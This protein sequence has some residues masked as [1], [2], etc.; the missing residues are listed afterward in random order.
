MES[1]ESI[2][3]LEKESTKINKL[4]SKNCAH[5]GK[6]NARSCPCKLAA[7]CDLECQRK[8]W[9]TH[10]EA[11][12]AKRAS[13]VALE[14]AAVKAAA[15]LKSLALEEALDA[16]IEAEKEVTTEPLKEMEKFFVRPNNP[17]DLST[18]IDQ[19]YGAYI[20]K[21]RQLPA[22][23]YSMFSS[24]AASSFSSSVRYMFIE[25]FSY[26]IPHSST[27]FALSLRLKGYKNILEVGAGSGLWTY[28]L[29]GLH[30]VPIRATDILDAS[31]SYDRR[32]KYLPIEKLDSVASIEKYDPEVLMMVWAP[33]GTSMAY[34][35]LKAFKGNLLV[36]IGESN[37]GCTGNADFFTELEENWKMIDDIDMTSWRGIHDGCSIWHRKVPNPDKLLVGVS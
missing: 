12:V 34:E 7:Y 13:L 35:S 11:C 1:N 25:H 18:T 20:S 26:A 21:M 31:Y 8:A 19:I 9:R 10:K 27:L 32:Y 24:D 30:D 36:W 4:V 2:S 3:S 17:A 22:V 29:S 15:S 28:L 6:D 16:I 23:S 33:L 14:A 37:G 5:C